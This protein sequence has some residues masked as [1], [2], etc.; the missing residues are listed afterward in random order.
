MIGF[1]RDRAMCGKLVS[2][3]KEVLGALLCY[4]LQGLGE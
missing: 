3:G 2:T 4:S 1:S